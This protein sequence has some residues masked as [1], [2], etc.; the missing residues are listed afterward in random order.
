MCAVLGGLRTRGPSWG[1]RGARKC[2]LTG[3]GRL[4][5][6]HCGVQEGRV[7]KLAGHTQPFVTRHHMASL[8]LKVQVTPVE[9]TRP[10]AT[11]TALSPVSPRQPT[12]GHG[13]GSHVRP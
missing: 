7:L 5:S 11:Q 13:G 9:C 8:S 2:K 6:W 1:Q 10:R 3:T 4:G 12:E